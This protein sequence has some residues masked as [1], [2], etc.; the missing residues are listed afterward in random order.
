MGTFGLNCSGLCPSKYFGM[1]CRLRC[2]CEEDVCD[3]E[4]GC[5]PQTDWSIPSSP[6]STPVTEILPNDMISSPY[7][8]NTLFTVIGSVGTLCVIVMLYF[9]K[10]WYIRIK[11]RDVGSCISISENTLANNMTLRYTNNESIEDINHN[12][13]YTGLL[14]ANGA[15]HEEK[16]RNITPG[17]GIR[18]NMNDE[19]YKEHR[20]EI[21]ENKTENLDNEYQD[22]W[23][24]D[25]FIKFNTLGDSSKDSNFTSSRM[26]N[27]VDMKLRHY[28]SVKYNRKNNIRETKGEM[29]SACNNIGDTSREGDEDQGNEEDTRTDFV[30]DFGG[31][32]S[33]VN[34]E[35]FTE[36]VKYNKENKLDDTKN[37]NQDAWSAKTF[38]DKIS[39]KRKVRITQREQ[40]VDITPKSHSF[41]K[42]NRPQKTLAEHDSTYD[43]ID[44]V[45]VKRGNEYETYEEDTDND[46]LLV[47]KGTTLN[48]NDEPYK[49]Q[50]KEEITENKAEN[51]DHKYQDAWSHG[52]FFEFKTLG[53]IPN[54]SNL[55]SSRM[56]NGV[57]M[58]L[59]PYSSVKYNRKNNVR[60][61]KGDMNSAFNNIGDISKVGDEDQRNE[62][63]TKTD[64]VIDFGGK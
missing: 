36:K 16:L 30:V 32:T 15:M 29:N 7:W 55:T 61:T 37:E 52:N 13:S 33:F 23:S 48:T 5:P 25:N 2:S 19:P 57:D 50:N 46:T 4:V 44:D 64:F 27:G 42:Y 40:G 10:T 35:N 17:N 53:N 58:K 3:R 12:N 63:N 38:L 62:D 51:I 41:I 43:Y 22:A 26:N 14:V 56:N 49:K 54:D 39:R 6:T 11:T 34:E 24:D 31:S 20:E 28:S 60:E 21:T 18:T 45:S 9:V 1:L 59:R 47:S 8:K